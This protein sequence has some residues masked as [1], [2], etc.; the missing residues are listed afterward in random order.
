MP[1]ITC[2]NYEGLLQM[3]G[4]MNCEPLVIL[5]FTLERRFVILHATSKR[6]LFT[7]DDSYEVDRVIDFNCWDK[8]K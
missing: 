6:I 3:A 1:Y 7:N 5:S 8:E 4:E 2:Y